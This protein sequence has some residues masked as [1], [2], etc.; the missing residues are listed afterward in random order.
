MVRISLLWLP[1]IQAAQPSTGFSKGATSPQ[2]LNSEKKK[3]VTLSGTH[4]N[5]KK[6]FRIYYLL[7]IYPALFFQGA[8]LPE[9]LISLKYC[10]D[11]VLAL[12]EE[13]PII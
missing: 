3:K 2:A 1:G 12:L 8:I 7:N 13:K 5:D 9:E 6:Q 11:V 4:P 10:S